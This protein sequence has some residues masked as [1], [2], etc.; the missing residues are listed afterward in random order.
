M[1]VRREAVRS[2]DELDDL[3][4]LESRATP[5]GPFHQRPEQIPLGGEQLLRELPGDASDRP[6]LGV[7]LEAPDQKAADLLPEVHQVVRVADHGRVPG[8][9]VPRNRPRD[10]V[11]VHQRDDGQIY[12]DHRGDARRPL[13][14]RVH[15][16]LRLDTTA[17]RDNFRYPAPAVKSDTGHQRVGVDFHAALTRH[18][19]QLGGD[20]VGLK[21]AVVGDM[22]GAV[23][24]RVRHRRE[25][26]QRLARGDD[27][28]VEAQRPGAA[29]AALERLQHR[30][31]RGQPEAPDLPPAGGLAHV[32][33]DG[34]VESDA[35]VHQQH[36]GRRGSELRHQAHGVERRPAGQLAL[37]DEDDVL[38]P[39]L[40]QVIRDA[41]AGDAAANHHDL[42]L[43]P[44]A[45][46]LP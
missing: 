16:A 33:L 37:L 24:A 18:P 22:H 28:D 19:R 35:V 15:H 14:R 21:V 27:P 2:V 3:G 42:R 41:A 34:V 10:Q 45:G 25:D 7:G 9:M 29:H 44:H 40:G 31:A 12:A 13:P 26:L 43:I 6:G 23:E 8:K 20:A 38:E 1:A 11:L 32:G 39:V 4:L 46:S 36:V 30:R 5:H 17:I